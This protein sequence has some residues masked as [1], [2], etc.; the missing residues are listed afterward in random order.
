MIQ[1]SL[2]AL[3]T[4]FLENGDVDFKAFERLI[5]WHI[6]QKTNGLVICG[7]T[8]ESPTL[9]W[10]EQKELLRIA[11]QKAKGQLFIIMGTGT[12]DT[13]SSAFRTK[14]AQEIGADACLV[15]VPY[16]NKPTADGCYEHF[17]QVASEGLPVIL[18]HHPG[19]TGIKLSAT[20]LKRILSIPGIMGIKE[21]SG[22]LELVSEIIR[23]CKTRVFCG[24][25][26]L[27]LPMISLG[28]CGVIS[29]VAN[30]IP[31]AWSDFCSTCLSGDFRSARIYHEKFLP[32]CKSLFQDTNPQ[33]VKYAASLLGLCLPILR[34]PLLPPKD[35]IKG[36]IENE[37]R[38]S[39]AGCF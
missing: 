26:T 32:L 25:D 4:P 1:G 23:G 15:I 29:V 35:E 31:A 28:A 6:E 18:Y 17:S 36:K 20:D 7:T 39:F 14:E 2:V 22:D 34:L 24:D 12:N 33:G 21:S 11:V 13:R 27:T 9:L 5:D 30:I 19:R 8:G 3:I 38:L 10:E 16:Y 37:M